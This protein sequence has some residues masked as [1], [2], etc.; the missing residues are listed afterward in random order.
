M[1]QIGII[2]GSG[3]YSLEG[4]T[5]IEEV[6]VD[7]PFG[8]TSD[9][10]VKGCLS[11]STLF[12]LPRHGRNHHLTPSEVPYRANVWALKS[13]GVQWVLSASAVGSLR[14]VIEP[15]HMVIVDQFIDRTKGRE[16]TFFREGVVAHI[17]FGDPT[18]SVLRHSLAKAATEAGATIHNG[19]TYVC[20]EG[21]AFS[22]RAESHMYRAWGGDVIGMTNLPEAKLAREAEI[23]YATLGMATDYDCWNEEEENVSVE[24]VLSVLQANAALARSVVRHLVFEIERAQVDCSCK[25]ALDSALFTPVASM[26]EAVRRRLAPLLA[27][28]MDQTP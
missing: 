16:S 26:P 18:C 23:S 6:I 21:P 9:A 14:K 25:H 7:T 5:D 11:N 24:Q 27:R 2:G 12:F 3:L 22:T 15:G 19:G 13:L 10:I 8:P 20:M 1:A 17:S 4:L 28:H